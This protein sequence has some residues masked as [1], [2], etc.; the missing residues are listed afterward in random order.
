[1]TELLI[2]VAW[3][4]ITALEVYNGDNFKYVETFP[5][6]WNLLETLGQHIHEYYRITV[7]RDLPYDPVRLG[8]K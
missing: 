5:T 1:M 8:D 2:N 7:H 4:G 6:W 3:D